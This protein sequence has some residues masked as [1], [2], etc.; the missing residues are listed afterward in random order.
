[1][2][3]SEAYRVLEANCGIEV[4]DTVKVLRRVVGRG[5]WGWRLDWTSDMDAMIGKEYKVERFELGC[6][7]QL[8]GSSGY[9]RYFPFF[10]LEL[11]KKGAKHPEIKI[12]SHTVEFEDA[13]RVVR[14][15]CQ[16]VTFFDVKAIYE[17]MLT[18]RKGGK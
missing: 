7:F 11:V 16:S 5:R 8:V 12:G 6:G 10:V 4:G 15:G 3:I 9:R 18:L 17:H 2:Q 13:G 1:M 14:V